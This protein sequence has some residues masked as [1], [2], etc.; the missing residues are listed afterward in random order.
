MMSVQN[1]PNSV[2]AATSGTASAASRGGRGTAAP[3][4]GSATGGGAEQVSISSAGRMVNLASTQGLGGAASDTRV[5][6]LQ[7][8]VQ[9]GQYVVDPQ[10]IARGLLQDSQALLAATKPA[11]N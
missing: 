1:T 2:S 9:S 5:A 11:G 4:P 6:E 10:R 3:A 7:A 8:A